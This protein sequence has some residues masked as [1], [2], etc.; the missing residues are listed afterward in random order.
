[1]GN[2]KPINKSQARASNVPTFD[3]NKK[4]P[5]NKSKVNGGVFKY[6]GDVTVGELAKQ[7]NLNPTDII[8]FLFLQKKMVN[9]NQTLSDDLIAEICV[10]YGYDFQ[11]EEAVDKEDF[12]NIVI[13][14]DE[15]DLVER[16]PVVC[17]M[18]HVDHGKTTLIDAIRDSHVA[19]KEAGLI[20]Q[21]I[22]A[23]Q[24]EINGKKITF[25]D[26]PGHEAF[27][28]MRA[29]GAA[30][31]DI[32]L[33]VVA[34][35]DGVMPQTVEAINHAKAA[36]VTI[37][38][39]INKIDKPTANID[40]VYDELA[41]YELIPE[42]WGGS[43]IFVK[44]SAKKKIGIDN[45]LETILVV[46]E[47]KELKANPNRYALGSVVEASLD[48]NEGPK[49]TLLIQNG[50]LKVGD[51]LVIGNY[52]CKVRRMVNEYRQNISTALPS[53]PVVVTGIENVP[54]AG[55]H[56][57]AFSSEKEAREIADKRQLR[58]R[59]KTL[60]KGPAAS[61]DELFK[62]I[63]DGDIKN[64]NIILKADTTGSVE[65]LKSSLNKIQVDGVKINI[66]HAQTGTITESDI[67]LAS[68]SKALIYGFNIRPNAAIRQ[69]AQEEKVE[70][71]LHDIIYALTEEIE[72]AMKGMMKPVE[73]ETI[74]GQAEVRQIFTF[75]KVGTIAGCYVTEGSV[76]RGAQCR[77]IRNG[78]VI[79]TSKIKSL[80]REKDDASEVKKGFECGITI[81]NYNDEKEEDIIEAF[82]VRLVE[83]Q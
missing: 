38:V 14:D 33:I 17:V 42:E 77:I 29:R 43:T 67:A 31:T 7:L 48:R 35:D 47:L 62:Q 37:I 19:D 3:K 18:G 34:A 59:D 21:Q 27:T 9:I 25:L 51:S 74:L 73:Q 68:A 46:A 41:Q 10:E 58:E 24:K 55:D 16:P 6:T 20:T 53:T 60:N 15:K 83:R 11:K 70:I 13:H 71:H 39:V 66:I 45:L 12:E 1:M 69:K 2:K 56:F 44:V 57:M 79:Y 30:V 75:S 82:E 54:S 52:Y 80:R 22:G 61:L 40:R 8:R 36:N 23:Y 50:T 78:V 28:Q 49:A 63:Q 76:K 64:V 72:N 26:T 65:A 5:T 32:A 4:V 81:E